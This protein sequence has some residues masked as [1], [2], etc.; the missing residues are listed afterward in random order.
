MLAV[1]LTLPT[2]A[3][4]S[5]T[6]QDGQSH[7][8][9]SAAVADATCSEIALTPGTYVGDIQ[10]DRTVSITGEGPVGT[11]IVSRGSPC[12]SLDAGADLA[13]SGVTIAG[14]RTI[15]SAR[16]AKL[17]LNNSTV[18]SLSGDG[19]G[20][21][22]LFDTDAWVH[23][24]TFHLADREALAVDAVSGRGHDMTFDRVKF[25]GTLPAPKGMGAV[26]ALNYGVSCTDC[27]FGAPA[28]KLT[29]P[30]I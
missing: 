24:V 18:A 5:V 14:D 7:D 11:F 16:E 2:L 29:I 12:L 20:L 25:L 10:V 27:I 9:L 23:G 26:Y 6:C 1:L 13:L 8:T 17:R 19:R 22:R 30:T 21:L 4:A 3:M 15:I 28:E